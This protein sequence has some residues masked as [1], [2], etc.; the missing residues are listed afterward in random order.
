MPEIIVYLV[1]VM[2]VTGPMPDPAP[3]WIL[4]EREPHEGYELVYMKQPIK[5]FELFSAPK[6]CGRTWMT[7]TVKSAP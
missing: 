4:I 1:C 3:P 5:E 2:I 7:V 6:Q